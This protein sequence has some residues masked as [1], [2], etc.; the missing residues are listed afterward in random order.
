MKFLCYLLYLANLTLLVSRG[1][2]TLVLTLHYKAGYGY[3]DGWTFQVGWNCIT[4]ETH[5]KDLFIGVNTQAYP[6]T[7]NK[8]HQYGS[9]FTWVDAANRHKR[10]MQGYAC[11]LRD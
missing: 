5:H 7:A 1:T 11:G 2:G 9:L 8:T 3:T 4:P 6:T 10:A